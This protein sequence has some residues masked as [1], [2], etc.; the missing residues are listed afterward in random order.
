MGRANRRHSV[1]LLLLAWPAHAD[2]SLRDTAGGKSWAARCRT[3]FEKARIP[4][5]TL[6]FVSGKG[7]GT[8][9]LTVG[10]KLIASVGDD[11]SGH[12]YRPMKGLYE[13]RYDQ[14]HSPYDDSENGNPVER[15][16]DEELHH[17]LAVG[18]LLGRLRGDGA[19]AATVK[20]II[21]ACVADVLPL[22]ADPSLE[23]TTECAKK[24]ERAFGELVR[25]HPVFAVAGASCGRRPYE[26]TCHAYE[27]DG[28]R[29]NAGTLGAF[30]K[31]PPAWKF[32]QSAP[33]RVSEAQRQAFFD[34]FRA[35]LESCRPQ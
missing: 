29:F 33:Q 27:G 22:E 25:A 30:S 34:A 3:R 12:R 15:G 5:G 31:E 23:W 17:R 16:F 28:V 20:P 1:A 10:K 6:A 8:L 35:P 13:K 7:F 4:G 9:T 2:T 18:V 19:L 24:L 14:W 26:A 21:D 32:E 11:D